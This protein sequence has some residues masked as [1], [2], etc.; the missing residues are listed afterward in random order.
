MHFVDLPKSATSYD[1]S[2]CPSPPG[3]VV[4]ALRNF[5][6]SLRRAGPQGDWCDSHSA[7]S[8]DTMV[9]PCK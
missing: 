3:C 4:S 5:T 2:G 7:R 6:S 8:G 9:Q 1:S